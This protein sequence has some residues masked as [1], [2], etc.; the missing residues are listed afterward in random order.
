MAF[1]FFNGAPT[2]Q[3][4]LEDD[5]RP[6][7]TPED[8][9]ENRLSALRNCPPHRLMKR[10][11]YR[12]ASRWPLIVQVRNREGWAT[13]FYTTCKKGKK[14]PGFESSEC[15]CGRGPQTAKFLRSTHSTSVA[16]AQQKGTRRGRKREEALLSK[17]T[18]LEKRFDPTTAHLKGDQIHSL[19]TYRAIQVLINANLIPIHF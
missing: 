6:F 8:D 14:V 18:Q 16:Y 3:G 15:P 13:K 12:K 11:K 7:E 19:R 2:W 5:R 10:S 17:E 9:W 4:S 1:V